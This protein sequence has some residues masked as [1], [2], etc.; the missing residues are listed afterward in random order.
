MHRTLLLILLLLVLA[1]C[2]DGK[3]K[4]PYSDL[5]DTGDPVSGVNI[6]NTEVKGAAACSACHPVSGE[7]T[8]S[9]SLFGY[10]ARADERV[11][12]QDAR[13]YT[14]WSIVEPGQHIVDGFGNAMYNEYDEKLTPQQI[15]DMIAYLL[16]L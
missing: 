13:E 1:A 6:F 5:P 9:P 2:D 3:S 11:Q 4:I 12:G 10:A 8:G 15:A 16:R 14:F 7:D